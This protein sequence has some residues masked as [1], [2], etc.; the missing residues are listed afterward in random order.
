MSEPTVERQK[1]IARSVVGG[2]T[3]PEK[4]ALR[5]WIEELLQIKSSPSPVLLKAKRAVEATAKSSVIFP[6][7][8]LIS[9]EITPAAVTRL[10]QQLVDVRQSNL[11]TLAKSKQALTLVGAALKQTSWDER[12]LP[13]RLGLTSAVV[14]AIV[15][16]SQAAGIAALGGAIGV[17]LW[18][19]FGAGATFLGVLYQEITGKEPPA[20]TTYRVVDAARED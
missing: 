12:G 15:F 13:A 17:P 8:K 10:S 3:P 19:I 5:A 18:V 11:S 20:K 7:V 2:A 1:Q 6:L 14:A 4:D 16:G 9:R